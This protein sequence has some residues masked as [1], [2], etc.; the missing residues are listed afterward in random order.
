MNRFHINL[1]VFLYKLY[2]AEWDN[3]QAIEVIF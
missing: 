2:K 1:K 3:M